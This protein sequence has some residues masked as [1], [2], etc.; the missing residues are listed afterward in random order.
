MIRYLFLFAALSGLCS[1]IF[2]AFGAHALAG[3]LEP[4]M[5]AAFQT[6]VQYQMSHTLILFITLLIR[7]LKQDNL[8]LELAC[9]LFIAGIVLF[10]GSLYML[11][12][13]GL[14]W[15]GPVTPLG[16]LMFITGWLLLAIGSWRAQDE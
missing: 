4:R 2:G 12:L 3:M 1:V 11:S 8:L 14:H 13:T 16:G 9:Y 7:D 15:L 6:G 5:L 10:S